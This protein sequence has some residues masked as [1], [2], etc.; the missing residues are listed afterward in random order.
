MLTEDID[1]EKIIISQYH[2][3]SVNLTFLITAET[4]AVLAETDISA[5]IEREI[6]VNTATVSVRDIDAEKIIISQ[7]HFN[8]VNL[9]FLITAET[10]AVL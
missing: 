9:T 10:A 4:A 2:F 8:S 5:D 1:A 7:Y 6:A 3:N